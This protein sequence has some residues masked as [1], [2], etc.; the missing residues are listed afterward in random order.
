MQQDMLD[1]GEEASPETALCQCGCGQP[2]P[3]APRNNKA[4]GWV[5]G[6]PVRFIWGHGRRKPPK[7]SKR[8]ACRV[9]PPLVGKDGRPGRQPKL[10]VEVGQ[11]FGRGVVLDP[12]IRVVANSSPTGSR[13]GA[14]LRCDCG[15]EYAAEISSLR[16]G[17]TQSCGC[18]A[19]EAGR[20]TAV[21]GK[22][23]PVIDRTGR[24]YGMLTV[25]SF[26]D[27]EDGHARWLCQCDCGSEPVI[28][29]H[30]RL[31]RGGSCGCKLTDAGG[32][33]APKGK[34]SPGDAARWHVLRQYQKNAEARGHVW[35]LTEEDFDR[36]TSSEC[37]YCGTP[38]SNGF[39]TGKYEGA[40]FI[41]NGID[42][43]DNSAGYVTGNVYPCCALCNIS[44]GARTY[45]TFMEWIGRL[46][47]HN[48]FQP[49]R[50]P[51]AMIAKP[52]LRVVRDTHTA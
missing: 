3:I 26:V 35:E 5:K 51:S 9:A 22:G 18:L 30:W 14:W 33:S 7:K 16:S 32:L 37:F 13:R 39:S 34:R 4:R 25:L 36:L 11:R 44:K 42:R 29:P 46:V 20:R 43:I 19:D 47:A 15:N 49:E 8:R 23:R 6:Q 45:A 2:A 17:N 52:I 40:G 21:A 1:F 48:M 50:V 27:T 28:V 24:R 38:P 31:K 12:E 10:L 41:Y